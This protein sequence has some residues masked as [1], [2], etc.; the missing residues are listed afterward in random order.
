MKYLTHL[1]KRRINK[2][3]NKKKMSE[4]YH[5]MAF[6]V[7]YLGEKYLGFEKQRFTNMTIEH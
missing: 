5:K 3:G 7:G 1:G 6:K 4:V 2:C